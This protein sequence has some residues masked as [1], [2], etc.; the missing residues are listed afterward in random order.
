MKHKPH[1]LVN[2][3]SRAEPQR[4][5]Y[6]RKVYDCYK[7]GMTKY[8]PRRNTASRHLTTR[9]NAPEAV[10]RLFHKKEVLYAAD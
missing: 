6:R 3:Q 2:V 10:K 8:A 7:A 4:A 5:K 1:T 9:Q